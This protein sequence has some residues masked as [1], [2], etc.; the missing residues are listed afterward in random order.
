MTPKDI[1]RY[2]H[3]PRKRYAGVR[4]QQGRLLLDS[5]FNESA[6]LVAEERREVLL[7]FLGASAS[8][9]QGFS[10][11]QPVSAPIPAQSSALSPG[12]ALPVATV[13]LG[14]ETVEARNPSVRAGSYYLGGRRL[15]IEA[16]GAAAVP[17]RLLADPS[18]GR[19]RDPRAGRPG[20]PG[21]VPGALLPARVGSGVTAVEDPEIARARA[22]RRRTRRISGG[23]ACGGAEVFG[24]LDARL[25]ASCTAAWRSLLEGRR[26]RAT[27]T[28]DAEAHRRSCVLARSAPSGLQG[29][30]RHHRRLH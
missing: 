1:S 13:A 26:R 11:G 10:L 15:T 30:D 22:R 2:L 16:L 24:N 23:G 28:Y 19:A 9:D 12:D 17:A 3:Q 6:R 4:L 25:D 20:R 14:E 27:L 7:D 18:G 29:T 5:D 21:G 8:P